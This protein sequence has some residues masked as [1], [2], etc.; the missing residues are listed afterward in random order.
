MS[1]GK[2]SDCF[3]LS[4]LAISLPFV[5][6]ESGPDSSPSQA[7][8]DKSKSRRLVSRLFR[9][10]ELAFLLKRPSDARALAQPCDIRSERWPFLEIDR[11]SERPVEHGHKVGIG[12]T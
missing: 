2:Y 5:A 8:Q 12:H 10:V 4:A 7:S 6:V 3:L 9:D 11:H 1:S